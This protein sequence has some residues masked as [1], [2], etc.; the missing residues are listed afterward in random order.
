MCS[1]YTEDQSQKSIH[2]FSPT[3]LGLGCGVSSLS[4]DDQ[5]LSPQPPPPAPQWD[6][7]AFLASLSE[8]GDRKE[9]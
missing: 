3:Y 4:G 1:F 9:S 8:R 2:L 7:E 6:T 5:I